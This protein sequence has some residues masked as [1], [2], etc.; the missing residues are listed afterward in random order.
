MYEHPYLKGKN[1]PQYL[2]L[3]ATQ[4]KKKYI[5][6]TEMFLGNSYTGLLLR[7]KV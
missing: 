5:P 7:Q 4:I 6:T 1:R 3:F 2:L